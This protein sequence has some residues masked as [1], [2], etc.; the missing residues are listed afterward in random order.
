[1][2]LIGEHLFPERLRLL[3]PYCARRP[4]DPPPLCWSAVIWSGAAASI[5]VRG[6][7]ANSA[8][9]AWS[10]PTIPATAFDGLSGS[11]CEPSVDMV[12]DSRWGASRRPSRLFH[13]YLLPVLIVRAPASARGAF[14][15]GQLGTVTCSSL[16]KPSRRDRNR[17]FRLL[18]G[19]VAMSVQDQALEI[20]GAIDDGWIR[21][22]AGF[23]LR[24]PP[25]TFLDRLRL[26]WPWDVALFS[27]SSRYDWSGECV[28]SP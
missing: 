6:V 18:T 17:V 21:S 4:T 28:S 12:M 27:I 11:R 10:R 14:R 7:I 3:P 24:E 19:S 2:I 23:R 13:T 26:A 1:V 15:A 9:D 22:R 20:A 5:A 16:G 25:P 8:P